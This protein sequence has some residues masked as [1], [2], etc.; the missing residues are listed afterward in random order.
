MSIE[1][2]YSQLCVW[3]GT[4]MGGQSPKDFVDFMMA[5]FGVRVRFDAEVT[6]TAPTED[7]GFRHDLLFYVCDEDIPKF[8]VKRLCFGIRYWEDVLD[9]GNGDVYPEEVIQAHPYM[10]NRTSREEE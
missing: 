3:P 6:T 5:E 4:V 2:K 9:N 8:A 10:W 1:E 7:G